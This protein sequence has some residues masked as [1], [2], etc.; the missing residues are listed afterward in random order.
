M[1]NS[2]RFLF[3]KLDLD[4]LSSCLYNEDRKKIKSFNNDVNKIFYNKMKTSLLK[5]ID[6]RIS[7]V[8]I[9][10]INMDRINGEFLSNNIK[11]QYNEFCDNTKI[12]KV[13]TKKYPILL[14]D[15]KSSIHS[16]IQSYSEFFE[17]YKKNKEK[18]CIFFNTKGILRDVHFGLGDPHRNH[19]TVIKIDFEDKSI[20]YKPRNS[21][22]DIA[23]KNVSK[24][25][26]SNG[27]NTFEVPNC[28]LYKDYS[29]VDGISYVKS[30]KN[31]IK[32]IYYQFGSLAAIAYIFN[33]SDLHMEN[34]IVSNNQVYLID[35]ETL[36]QDNFNFNYKNKSAKDIIYKDL[37][38]SVLMT[39]L[40][41]ALLSSNKNTPD[42]SGITGHGNQ[43]FKHRLSVA[44]NLF[45]SKIILKKIDYRNK[46]KENIP[47][48]QDINKKVNPKVYTQNI[49]D[50]FY[51]TYSAI[52][53]KKTEFIN[54][55]KI[56][57]NFNKGIY[58]IVFKN[59]SAY[60]A[61]L[62]TMNSPKYAQSSVTT[63][64]LLNLLRS[65]A[66]AK[67]TIY[68]IFPSEIEDLH[69]GDIPYFYKKA[70]GTKVYNSKNDLICSLSVFKGIDSYK[71]KILQLTNKDIKRQVTLIRTSMAI[72][73]KNWDLGRK[74]KYTN[75][76]LNS[77]S[78][79]KDV[80]NEAIK[81]ILQNIINN[82]I[83]YKKTINWENI[84]ITENSNWVISPC[85]FSLYNGLSGISITFATAYKISENPKYL[86]TLN[87]CLAEIESFE[88]SMVDDFN[89]YSGFNGKGSLV[90][91]YFFLYSLFQTKSFLNKGLYYLKS[92]QNN[93]DMINGLDFLDG[94]AGILTVLC[95]IQSK[96]P[97]INL[98]EDIK[99][100]TDIIV[101]KWNN[102]EAWISDLVPNQHLNGMSHGISGI[103]YALFKAREFYSDSN[104]DKLLRKAVQIEDTGIRNNNWID[105]RNR[106]NRIKNGF[107][108]PVHWCHGAPGIGISRI[109]L[110][111]I[112]NTNIDIELAKSCILEKGI[113]GSDCLCHG[114]LGNIELFITDYLKNNNLDSLK[115]AQKIAT[116]LCTNKNWISGIPQKRNVFGLMT[117]MSGMAYELLR[118]I[119]P[120]KV[121]S[122]LGLELYKN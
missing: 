104:L 80:I 44:E 6:N 56:W 34:V 105:L 83:T 112:F 94:A 18:I 99:T 10:E 59:T 25:L 87:G 54:N 106:K 68:N 60:N 78:Y 9:I 52:L 75:E 74:T 64:D 111:K 69:N 108:D 120:K 47:Y 110:D 26:E 71:E 118:T 46:S 3:Y 30:N 70:A 33:L 32:S 40:F 27:I 4:I 24:W 41:P 122:I 16:I 103:I 62:S 28:I 79:D 92:L 66:N 43:L 45:T 81:N 86:E 49:L 84:A 51:D 113:G 115:K 61:I 55:K 89:N 37:R 48:T 76:R 95:E 101:K 117:G 53:N 91:L 1:T 50:G 39:G 67:A 116:D 22:G 38:Q 114:S 121:P 107:P 15:L 85:D 90:Y 77:I 11:E 13:L 35:A 5:Y 19:R 102:K 20:Y 63:N 73:V 100:V 29:W 17:R 8:L 14:K 7:K 72:P 36:L 93:I 119:Y 88:K 21:Y 42:I 82:N 12:L 96:I 58:R 57:D 2:T 65:G 31:K 23:I 109:F 98:E 97:N